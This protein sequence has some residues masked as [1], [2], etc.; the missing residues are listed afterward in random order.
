ML[1][2]HLEA[3]SLRRF[4]DC[5]RLSKCCPRW[6]RCKSN[7]DEGTTPHHC[8]PPGP[9]TRTSTDLRSD[10]ENWWGQQ[11]YKKPLSYLDRARGE[12]TKKSFTPRGRPGHY[13]HRGRTSKWKTPPR[14]E[15]TMAGARCSS[16]PASVYSLQPRSKEGVLRQ[17]VYPSIASALRTTGT[18][19]AFA[20]N[21]N[22]EATI[23]NTLEGAQKFTTS[24]DD[25][26]FVPEPRRGFL[27]RPKPRV[28]LWSDFKR[29]AAVN[30]SWPLHKNFSPGDLKADCLRR[31]LWREEGKPYSSWPLPAAVPEVSIRELSIS[32]EGDGISYL[33]VE[34]LHAPTVV[35]ETGNSEPTRAS[36]PVPT[37]NRFEAKGLRYR[38][39]AIDPNDVSRC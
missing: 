17:I 24:I 19:L 13:K 38:F 3:Y 20:G 21:Q 15:S 16:G 18:D 32:D 6:T 25:D 2:E 35:Y 10:W 26:S 14:I 22:G 7:Q 12:R 4:R 5:Y 36:S 11:L 30:T 29:A 23:R 39:L 27:V 8:P 33:K 28:V 31:G 37:P 9:R 1:V 34:P